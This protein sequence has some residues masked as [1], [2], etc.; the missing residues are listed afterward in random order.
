MRYLL[1]YRIG[2]IALALLWAWSSSRGIRVE[3]HK[4][5]FVLIGVAGAL[6]YFQVFQIHVF[7]LVVF[8]TI[9]IKDSTRRSFQL[10]SLILLLSTAAMASTVLWGSLVQVRTLS[11]QLMVLAGTAVILI[12]SLNIGNIQNI[13]I[14]F[15]AFQSIS[16]IISLFQV[17][18]MIP[19][20]FFDSASPIG[21]P[22]GLHVEPDWLGIYSSCAL[23]LIAGTHLNLRWRGFQYLCNAAA[24]AYS[25]CRGAW[26][27]ILITIIIWGIIRVLRKKGN[28]RKTS[29]SKNFI[30]FGAVFFFVIFLEEKLRPFMV[31]RFRGI[32]SDSIDISAQARVLQNQ[33]MLNLI[34]DGDWFGYG[35]S[36]S[37]RVGVLGGIGLNSSNNV[38]SNWLASLFI[39]TGI[40]CI[41][42]LVFTIF[43][44]IKSKNLVISLAFFC[45]MSNALISNCFYQPIFWL[46]LGLTIVSSR[47]RI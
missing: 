40:I 17:F 7:C 43:Y 42:F 41:P 18:H 45:L 23:I 36:A 5:L 32:F 3:K 6:P 12:Y 15:V 20:L 9:F 11:I 22:T 28:L 13:L 4:Y 14:G 19:G 26:I 25:G 2:A 39:D 46:F 44:L 24:L 37:G 10:P 16:A 30:T 1:F 34:R 27:S 31:S 47:V 33:T 21:R 35:I 8:C 29:R 38:A